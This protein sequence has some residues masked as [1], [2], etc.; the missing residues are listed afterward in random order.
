MWY[1]SYPWLTPLLPPPLFLLQIIIKTFIWTMNEFVVF[2]HHIWT[3]IIYR[4]RFPPF[5]LKKFLFSLAP[6]DIYF[7]QTLTKKWTILLLSMYDKCV[8]LFVCLCLSLFIFFIYFFYY[9]LRWI[10]SRISAFVI[11]RAINTIQ[12]I[13]NGLIENKQTSDISY[14]FVCMCV[15][16]LMCR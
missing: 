13:M 12:R 14:V 1:Q 2:L 15:F 6:F 7:W 8:L 4:T 3:R 10:C 11:F 5:I 9:L 16:M